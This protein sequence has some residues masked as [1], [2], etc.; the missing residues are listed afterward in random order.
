M[1]SFSYKGGF[2]IRECMH[3]KA[4]KEE[5]VWAIDKRLWLI[6]TK[7]LFKIVIPLRI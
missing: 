6:I 7:M 2:G 3:I 5:L 4:L 1:E